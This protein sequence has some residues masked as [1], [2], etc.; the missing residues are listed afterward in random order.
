M[1]KSHPPITTI[2]IA[3]ACIGLAVASCKGNHRPEPPASSYSALLDSVDF[4]DAQ[5]IRQPELLLKP[6]LSFFSFLENTHQEQPE[7][8]AAFMRKVLD[9]DTAIL[10]YMVDD[11]IEKYLFE[12]GSPIR[13]DHIY[14][15]MIDYVIEDP[16]IGQLTK[17]R[18]SAHA[19]LLD[20]NMPG[21][22]AN[23]FYFVDKEG[24]RRQLRDFSAV[25]VLLYFHNPDCEAC[26]VTTRQ[27]MNSSGLK[28]AVDHQQIQVIA[29]YPDPDLKPWR[30]STFP[31]KWFNVYAE[32]PDELN[33]LY[34]LRAIPCMYLL[35][36]QNRVRSKDGTIEEVLTTIEK[37]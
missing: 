4:G 29:V 21:S 13:N 15:R 24:V 18:F 8:I 19:A 17:N 33:V 12:A 2:A 31:D 16:R 26:K 30:T 27:L 5:L 6:S 32:K 37:M 22:G 20:Q 10:K 25:P 36:R 11:V 9:A 23:N 3:L 1:P 28:T 34:D 35:D 7:A 14:R